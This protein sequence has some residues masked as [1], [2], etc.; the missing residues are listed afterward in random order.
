[1]CEVQDFLISWLS[2]Y[3]HLSSS[4]ELRQYKNDSIH[5]QKNIPTLKYAVKENARQFQTCNY[6]GLNGVVLILLFLLNNPFL[7]SHFYTRELYQEN[8]EK[9]PILNQ[10][11]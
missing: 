8:H 6:F 9:E 11:S 3:S 2:W 4:L 7:K 1:M 5:T 10:K